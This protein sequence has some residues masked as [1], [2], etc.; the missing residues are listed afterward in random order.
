MT[1]IL[2]TGAA[3]FIGSHLTREILAR[4]PEARIL[5][6]DKFGYGG[7]RANFFEALEDPRLE[8]AELDLVDTDAF[9]AALRRFGP[10]QIY[11]L[12][13]ESHVDRSITGPRAFMDANII[14]AYS[15]L[16]ETLG[17]WRDLGGEDQE[18][19]RLLHVSTD[20]VFGSLGPEDPAFD[21][22][23]PYDPR[24]PYSASKAASDHLVRAWGHTYGLP[25][26]ITNCSN[27]FGPVQFPE[28]LIPVMILAAIE[29]RELPVYG[30]G[31]NRRDWLFVRDHVD[32]LIQVMNRGRIGR[33]YCVGGDAERDNLTVV[34]RICARLDV[35]RP[36]PDGSYL[37]QIA[38]VTDRPGHDRRYAIDASRIRGELGWRPSVGFEE[39][40]DQ[41]VDWYLDNLEWVRTVR[42]A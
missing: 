38:Y 9:G 11:H 22:A 20:E 18:R 5:V 1:R 15:V 26:L 34:R 13:A 37:D 21:E 41:T 35:V 25:A 10:G 7:H 16:Q 8:I 19:F 12:A 29:G 30:D 39:G 36:K 17:Y 28:K 40:L 32:A 4:E 33:T 2:I 24:S 31:L 6:V 42:R 23:T 27:N 3:G 14:G